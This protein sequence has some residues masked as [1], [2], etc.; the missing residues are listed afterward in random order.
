MA[1]ITGFFIICLVVLSCNSTTKNQEVKKEKP[2]MY[3]PSEMALLMRQIYEVNKVAKAQIIGKETLQS[4]P[5]K[6]MTIHSAVLT[7]STDRD[8]EFDV[9]A[10]QFVNYQ[11]S[12]F[13]SSSDSTVYYFNKSINTCITCHKTRCT[14]PIPKI[15]KLLIH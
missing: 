3:E 4:F 12:T 15:K 13:S 9:L 11:K 14:G 7:D 2:L 8:T 6:F 5:E 10:E 1:R